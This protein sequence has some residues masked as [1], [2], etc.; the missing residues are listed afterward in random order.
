MTEP[1]EP[2]CS[3]LIA[4]KYLLGPYDAPVV[5]L[6]K[7]PTEAT[8]D[9]RKCAIHFLTPDQVPDGALTDKKITLYKL[10]AGH[11]AVVR[12]EEVPESGYMLAV[13]QLPPVS[14]ALRGTVPTGECTA[15]CP[16]Y[17]LPC[18]L[19]QHAECINGRLTCQ[20]PI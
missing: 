7:S 14:P 12:L 13:E 6:L 16:P 4:R 20:P 8:E 9:V 10:P 15:S 19:T 11:V 17:T 5:V 2:T 18:K 3:C 1:C